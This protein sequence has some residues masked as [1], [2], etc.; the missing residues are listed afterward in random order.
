MLLL[1]V[2]VDPKN[3]SSAIQW[4]IWILSTRAVSLDVQ[5]EDEDLLQSPGRQLEDL[6]DFETDVFII[7]GGNA[8]V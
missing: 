7:G 6:I 4:K 3:E 8:Y 1:P 5:N 2:Q